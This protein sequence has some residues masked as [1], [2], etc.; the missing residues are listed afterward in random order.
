MQGGCNQL[1][2]PVSWCRVR[3]GNQNARL[4]CCLRQGQ[5]WQPLVAHSSNRNTGLFVED[6]RSAMW[7]RQVECQ[8][9]HSMLRT[10]Q[11]LALPSS[12]DSFGTF[13]S[14]PLVC[15]VVWS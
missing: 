13:G 11:S 5:R 12:S 15:R 4:H 1:V 3:L 2:V 8:G 6:V 14:A 9:R 7:G 10:V